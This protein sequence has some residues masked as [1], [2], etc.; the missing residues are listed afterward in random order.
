MDSVISPA[1]SSRGD[2]FITELAFGFDPDVDIGA[3][4]VFTADAEITSAA[5]A[6][7]AITV[8]RDAVAQGYSGT[9]NVTLPAG[10]TLITTDLSFAAGGPA[11]KVIQFR[12]AD[13]DYA[14]FRN[15]TIQ[16]MLSAGAGKTMTTRVNLGVSTPPNIVSLISPAYRSNLSGLVTLTVSAPGGYTTATAFYTHAPTAAKPNKHGYA[17]AIGPVS[18]NSQGLGT[19]TI[20]MNDVPNGTSR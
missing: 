20:D 6:V 11:A 10:W 17:A 12:V 2:L 7:A 1:P 13:D 5:G 18:L 19:I 14:L 3:Q 9:Y 15:V 4:P 16:P 8:T